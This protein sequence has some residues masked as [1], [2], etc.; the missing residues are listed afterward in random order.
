[1]EFLI[2]T[3]SG[4]PRTKKEC[5]D[6]MR[7]YFERMNPSIF[8]YLT[9]ELH[10]MVNRFLRDKSRVTDL[11]HLIKQIRVE[12]AE[13]VRV[14]VFRRYKM[15]G[16]WRPHI[17]HH[18]TGNLKKFGKLVWTTRQVTLTPESIM[19]SRNST[20]GH[21]IPKR[22]PL[23]KIV[24]VKQDKK[25]RSK[26]CI[27]VSGEENNKLQ[28]DAPSE[29]EAISWVLSINHAR[30]AG[31]FDES[32]SSSSI[33]G[34]FSNQVSVKVS[35][36]EL[37]FCPVPF[38]SKRGTYHFSTIVSEIDERLKGEGVE[39]GD[40][41]TAV[42]DWQTHGSSFS[43]VCKKMDDGSSDMVVTFRRRTSRSNVDVTMSAADRRA[44]NRASTY[45]SSAGV[46]AH[47]ALLHLL[48]P[49]TKFKTLTH[50]K[51]N[52]NTKTKNFTLEH[53]YDGQQSTEMG[54]TRA[55]IDLETHQ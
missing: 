20:R 46:R 10:E 40:V 9:D 50:N 44:M 43:T 23:R 12:V 16:L 13:Y 6:L 55:D 24:S 5:E 35:K 21:T 31:R 32:M 47:R 30:M 28:F 37:G 26:F 4:P 14:H 17:S 1:M 19:Y 48:V 54:V 49:L 39:N 36:D 42:N 8:T 25:D 27:S 7:K 22:V 11:K 45:Y 2:E 33:D 34:T 53:R 38:K 3:L 15:T 29:S 41:I 51:T 18:K 52:S